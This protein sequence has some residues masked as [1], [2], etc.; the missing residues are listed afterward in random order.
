[1]NTLFRFLAALAL[2]I[3]LATTAESDCCSEFDPEGNPY[4]TYTGQHEFESKMHMYSLT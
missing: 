1:M 4:G 3:A 2:L